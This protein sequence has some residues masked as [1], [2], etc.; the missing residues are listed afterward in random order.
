[1]GMPVIVEVLGKNVTGE[2]L[3]KIYDYFDYVDK[4]FSTYKEDSE[5]ERIN[6]GLVKPSEYSRDMKL[7]LALCEQTKL[8]TQ[9]YFNV[10]HKGRLDPSGLV[11][12]WAIYNAAKKLKRMGFKNYSVEAG[13]DIQVAGVNVKGK[14]WRIGIKNP[15][16]QDEI[17]KT[18][19]LKDQGVATSGIYIRGLHIYS[20]YTDKITKDIVSLTVIG[21]N[22]YEADRFATAAFAMGREGIIFLER[23]KG[24]EGYMI[25]KEGIATYTSGFA[26]YTKSERRHTQIN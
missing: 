10:W 24:F 2:D 5:V 18:L 8:Q 19:Y 3:D 6:Q 15:F 26:N 11:K 14:K 9:G 20:P 17:V 7:V 4:K 25:D 13:G 23:L 21:P 16:N 1:M 22:I 12:G